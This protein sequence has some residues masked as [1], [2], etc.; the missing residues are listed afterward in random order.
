MERR[1]TFCLIFI[2]NLLSA[3][4]FKS[5]NLEDIGRLNLGP[6]GLE[7]SYEL[8]LSKEI[9]WENNLGIGMGYEA[10]VGSVSYAFYLDSPTPFIKSQMKWLYNR[11]KRLSKGKKSQ[12][13]S[14]NLIGLQ[15]KYSFGN[16]DLFDNNRALLTEVHWGFQRSLGQRFIFNL[17]LGLGFV[18]DFDF[19]ESVFT[20][21]F[22]LR[23]GYRIF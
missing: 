22:G 3:Q 8:P 2:V 16:S 19:S 12:S 10:S 18:S 7:L 6:H 21:T 14:G 4:I 23:F 11:N 5:D 20:P 15:S 1:L 13:N 17:H 9:V